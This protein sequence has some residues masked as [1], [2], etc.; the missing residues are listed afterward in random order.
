[1]R[2]LVVS[3]C[4]V[5][6]LAVPA[7]A[8]TTSGGLSPAQLTAA[9]WTCFNVPVTTI[10]PLGV[11]CAP[12]GQPFPPTGQPHIQLL[13]FFHTTDPNSTV[14][15]FT[16]TETLIRADLYQGQ[17]CPTEPGPGGGYT[18]LPTIG[19]PLNYFGCHRQTP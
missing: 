4:A 14:P 5:I 12:P 9:G 11:H 19:L 3:L 18:F 1:M 15:D 7:T 2:R 17:P 6:A 10:G 16:G 8:S 13:Y